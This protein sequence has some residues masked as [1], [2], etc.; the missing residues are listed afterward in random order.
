M[1]ASSIADQLYYIGDPQISIPVPTYTLTP[2]A[3]PLELVYSVQQVSGA[4]LPAAI[5]LDASVPGSEK[6]NIW[7]TDTLAAN[8]H[9][10][11]VSAIDAKTTI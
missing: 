1:T 2:S 8:I 7:A 4:A 6:I 3:C 9:Q 11:R 10:V 5:Q